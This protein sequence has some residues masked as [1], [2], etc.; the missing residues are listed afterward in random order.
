MTELV[1][2]EFARVWDVSRGLTP[3]TF[4]VV[5]RPPESAVTSKE[6]EYRGTDAVSLPEA[7]IRRVEGGDQRIRC[8]RTQRVT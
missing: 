6:G 4:S 7:Y 1:N 5:S 3:P 2:N 8:V